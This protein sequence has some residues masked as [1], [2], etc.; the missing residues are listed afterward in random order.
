ME[1]NINWVSFMDVFSD[2]MY[3]DD[4]CKHLKPKDKTNIH[5]VNKE[6][7]VPS[8]ALNVHGLKGNLG[9]MYR[10]FSMSI[11]TMESVDTGNRTRIFRTTNCPLMM[12]PGEEEQYYLKSRLKL[13]SS[14]TDRC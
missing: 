3:F 10:P 2:P 7:R 6:L 13:L 8:S 14:T 1:G 12:K 5:L 11:F 9:K 4:L